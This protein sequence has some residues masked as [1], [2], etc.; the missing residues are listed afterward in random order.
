MLDRATGVW[1][2]GLSD[3]RPPQI[4]ICTPRRCRSRP[5][6]EVH[7]RRAY[8]RIWHRG[9]PVAPV[10]QLLLDY[11]ADAPPKPLA[12]A[13]A[14]A[15]YRGWLDLESLHAIT[16]PGRP[17]SAA[18]RRALE[19]HEPQ[20]AHSRGELERRLLKLCA[21]AG[22]PVPE[23]N[24]TV[25]GLLV[26]ALWRE[27]RVIVELD[28]R[29]GHRAW[30]QIQRDRERDLRLRA[31]GYLVLRYVWRQLE[32]EPEAVVADLLAAL[33]WAGSSDA[34]ASR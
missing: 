10:A 5:G 30:S 3:R 13:L 21:G 32:R 26:D 22:L 9:L 20:L 18:L 29:A 23:L 4:E 25:A 28:G 34:R 14:E 15:E 19:H 12:R 31:A 2:L 17:G 16:G 7:G 1:W 24:V 6:I 8:E 33:S 27:Q 11:A